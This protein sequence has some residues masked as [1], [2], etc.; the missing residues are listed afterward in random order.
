M[1]GSQC[2]CTRK[3]NWR[4]DSRSAPIIGLIIIGLKLQVGGKMHACLCC[5]GVNTL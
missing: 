3:C 1:K 2:C 4:E 5:M